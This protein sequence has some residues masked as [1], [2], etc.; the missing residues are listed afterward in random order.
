MGT[1]TLFCP[2]CWVETRPDDSDCPRCGFRMAA[3]DAIGYEGKLLLA[4]K[5]PISET[6]MLAI[7]L[8]GELKSRSAALAFA[9]TIEE[10]E[11]PYVLSAIVHALARIGGNESWAIIGRLRCHQSIIVRNTIKGV[12]RAVTHRDI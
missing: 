2:N 8:L 3:F 11:D 5:H 7:Q 9:T 10:E 6:R 4:L 1:I 12:D